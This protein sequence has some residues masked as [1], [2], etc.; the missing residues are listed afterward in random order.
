MMEF[1]VGESVEVEGGGGND[2]ERAV[3][4]RVMQ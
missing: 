1:I 2:C 4:S 3:R